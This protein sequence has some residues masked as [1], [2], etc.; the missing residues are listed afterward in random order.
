MPRV[1]EGVTIYLKEEQ[2]IERRI[3]KDV[4]DGELII[5]DTCCISPSREHVLGADLENNRTKG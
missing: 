3:T 1:I 2:E 4:G 5:T